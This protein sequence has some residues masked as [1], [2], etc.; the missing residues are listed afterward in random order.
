MILY[1][2]TDNEEIDYRGGVQLYST[3]FLISI[4]PGKRDYDS[5]AKFIETGEFE[6]YVEEEAD[7]DDDEIEFRDFEY[8][9]SD[10]EEKEE[11]VI[12]KIEEPGKEIHDEL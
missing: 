10:K 3:N 7:F 6:E 5:L 8:V 1:R 4:F 12:E 9:E 2:K 11:N